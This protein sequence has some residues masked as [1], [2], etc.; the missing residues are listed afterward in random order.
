MGP[1]QG[2]VAANFRPLWL[3][4]ERALV[5]GKG[6]VA[7]PAHPIA[8]AKR[9]AIAV[10]VGIAE[11]VALGL[12]LVEGDKSPQT[13]RSAMATGGFWENWFISITLL[14]QMRWSLSLLRQILCCWYLRRRARSSY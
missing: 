13:S 1:L 14:L 11:D 6:L 7:V 12:A 10:F 5:G 3:L 4:G 2:A 9:T 8:G